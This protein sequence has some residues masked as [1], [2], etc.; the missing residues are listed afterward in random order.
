MR[1]DNAYQ[2]HSFEM[3]LAWAH[4]HSSVL[5]EDQTL[6]HNFLQ[7]LQKTFYT[8]VYTID[9]RCTK[10][11]GKKQEENKGPNLTKIMAMRGTFSHFIL[12]SYVV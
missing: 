4:F 11:Y 6:L 12:I 9:N 7:F 8:I 1:P 5:K 10:C 2:V 3:K